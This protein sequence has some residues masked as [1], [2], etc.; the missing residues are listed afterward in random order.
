MCN[1]CEKEK[2]QSLC[3]KGNKINLDFLQMLEQHVAHHDYDDALRADA[4]RGA[5]QG[6]M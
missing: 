2:E 6:A 3:H 1:L 5:M 4:K